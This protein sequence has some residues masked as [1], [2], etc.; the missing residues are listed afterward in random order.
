MERFL[1]RLSMLRSRRALIAKYDKQ[2]WKYFKKLSIEKL[3]TIL[4]LT[5]DIWKSIFSFNYKFGPLY[6]AWYQSLLELGLSQK[7]SWEVIW[8]INEKLLTTFPRFV[9]RTMGRSNFYGMKKNAPI[10]VKRQTNGELHPNDWHI[11]FRPINASE[12]E[13]DIT[14][15]G[16]QKLARQFEC[17]DLLPGICRLDYLMSNLMENGFKRT[18]TLGDGDDCCNGCFQLHGT[19]GWAPERGFADRK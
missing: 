15:C 16:L 12:L 14:E 2:F 4:P 10:H 18:K 5:P 9:L 6:I 11:E 19:C 13:I 8:L 7:E 3:N 17:S 1:F